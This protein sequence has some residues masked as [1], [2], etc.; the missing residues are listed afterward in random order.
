M[1]DDTNARRDDLAGLAIASTDQDI[2]QGSPATMAAGPIA[3]KLS[4][5]LGC[6]ALVASQPTVL[7]PAQG[8]PVRLCHHPEAAQWT[9]QYD[10][11]EAAATIDLELQSHD[12]IVP[13]PNSL[14]RFDYL[15]NGKV[16]T[17]TD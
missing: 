2:D 10:R 5:L 12:G 16:P 15:L 8:P 14:R 6:P 13:E 9:N 7:H 3:R 1:T 17:T 11:Q 4:R